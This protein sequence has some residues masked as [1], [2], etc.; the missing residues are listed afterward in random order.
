MSHPNKLYDFQYA[1][2]QKEAVFV[3]WYP[4]SEDMKFC[5]VSITISNNAKWKVTYLLKSY[6]RNM[7]SICK[8]ESLLD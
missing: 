4:R 7:D 2:F 3:E 1:R 6:D 8:P 5:K